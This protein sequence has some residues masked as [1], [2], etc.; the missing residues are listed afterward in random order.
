MMSN[1]GHISRRQLFK[2]SNVINHHYLLLIPHMGADWCLVSCIS[3]RHYMTIKKRELIVMTMRIP[4]KVHVV[5]KH[6]WKRWNIHTPFLAPFS[7]AA[8]AMNCELWNSIFSV[9]Q[10]D[11]IITRLQ[12]SR[13][14]HWRK[15]SLA[16]PS[17]QL[18][19]LSLHIFLAASSNSGKVK[20]FTQG[21]KL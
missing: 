17:R 14:N 10:H 4:S 9:E 12:P 6:S 13:R 19:L 18:T 16:L 2:G 7:A 20:K 1:Q 11:H 15:M 8:A 3:H 21:A 5:Q